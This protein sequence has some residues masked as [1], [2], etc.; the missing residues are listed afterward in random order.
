MGAARPANPPKYTCTDKQEKSA[1]VPS[2][3]EI[4][5]VSMYVKTNTA[6]GART[7]LQSEGWDACH[8]WVALLEPATTTRGRLGRLATWLATA[9]IADSQPIL[10]RPRAAS[11]FVERRRARQL[12]HG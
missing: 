8:S 11:I 5:V 6:A 3:A 10:S 12:V 1:I 4:V 9:C 7:L 2:I